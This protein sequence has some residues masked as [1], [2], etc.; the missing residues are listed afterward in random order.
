MNSELIIKTKTNKNRSLSFF[1]YSKDNSINK[2]FNINSSGVL[3]QKDDNIFFEQ[4]ENI[5]ENPHDLL[6]IKKSRIMENI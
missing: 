2:K 4:G 1:D 6:S 3:L 5:S